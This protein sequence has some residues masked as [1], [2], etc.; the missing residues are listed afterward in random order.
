MSET[1]TKQ[2][3]WTGLFGGCL[4]IILIFGGLFA[5]FRYFQGKDA[6]RVQAIERTVMAPYWNA[7][8]AGDYEKA[9]ALRTTEWQSKHTAEELAGAYAEALEEHGELLNTYIHVANEF[10]EPGQ[11]GEACRV[12]SIYEFKDGLKTRVIFT[13]TRSDTE[14]VWHIGESA[15]PASLGLGDGPY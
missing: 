8:K 7:V 10:Y 13:L 4:V 3:S 14:S 12:E 15:V 1:S 2:G 6:E 11:K 5:T 9:H